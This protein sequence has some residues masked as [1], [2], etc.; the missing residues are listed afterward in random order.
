MIRLKEAINVGQAIMNYAL[1]LIQEWS[2]KEYTVSNIIDHD[3]KFS[4]A[5]TALINLDSDGVEGIVTD[6]EKAGF[7]IDSN[8]SKDYVVIYPPR[9]EKRSVPQ[10]FL[11]STA[12]T[13]SSGKK[14]DTDT[15]QDAAVLVMN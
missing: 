15:A 1:A 9:K 4:D 5:T 14:I 7:V 12:E 8:E 6:L 2:G 11:F 10:I 3:P 13:D